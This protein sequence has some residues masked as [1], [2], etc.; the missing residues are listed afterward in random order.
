MPWPE[1]KRQWTSAGGRAWL[2]L[3][4]LLTYEA[5][6][7]PWAIPPWM[8]LSW[9]T[10]P[11]FDALASQNGRDF[12]LIVLLFV[13]SSIL[14]HLLRVQTSKHHLNMSCISSKSFQSLPGAMDSH[15]RWAE[16]RGLSQHLRMAARACMHH[17]CLWLG[18]LLRAFQRRSPLLSGGGRPWNR[19]ALRRIADLIAADHVEHAETMSIL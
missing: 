16:R 13:V 5:T 11:G 3:M 4:T 6:A 12:L 9:W 8:P 19:P 1:S 2:A 10:A 14:S 18:G 17:R 7:A 15:G